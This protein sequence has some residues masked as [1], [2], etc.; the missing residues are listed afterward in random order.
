[1]STAGG[2]PGM[3]GGRYKELVVPPPSKLASQFQFILPHQSMPIIQAIDLYF[4]IS[5]G[6]RREPG[7]MMGSVKMNIEVKS[8]KYLHSG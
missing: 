3:R 2:R 5:P 1:M 7:A 6:G 4:N 8:M